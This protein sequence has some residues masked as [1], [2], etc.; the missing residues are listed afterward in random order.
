MTWWPVYLSVA[1]HPDRSFSMLSS[2]SV[3]RMR[4]RIYYYNSIVS[5]VSLCLVILLAIR[6]MSTSGFTRV[7]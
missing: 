6:A 5:L 3:L 7:A 2:G 4:Q 1:M